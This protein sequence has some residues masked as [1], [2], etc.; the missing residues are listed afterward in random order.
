MDCLVTGYESYF[1]KKTCIDLA[2]NDM[3]ELATICGQIYE[4]RKERFCKM[5]EDIT[6]LISVM[7]E[8]LM[9]R[10][11]ICLWD[12]YYRCFTFNTEDLTPTIEE[13]SILVRLEL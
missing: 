10:A 5:Y 7:V 11:T 13:Y 9:I 2:Q 8:E 3:I 12:L 4:A 1:L 6:S